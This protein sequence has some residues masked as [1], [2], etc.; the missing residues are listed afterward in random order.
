MSSVT[1]SVL[2]AW[3]SLTSTAYR[4]P[5]PSTLEETKQHKIGSDIVELD[6]TASSNVTSSMLSPHMSRIAHGEHANNILAIARADHLSQSHSDPQGLRVNNSLTESVVSPLEFSQPPTNGGQFDSISTITEG[7]ISISQVSR[8]HSFAQRLHGSDS[9]APAGG[10]VAVALKHGIAA[11][12]DNFTNAKGKVS[13]RHVSQHRSLAGSGHVMQARGGAEKESSQ[14]PRDRSPGR[15]E[16]VSENSG[17]VETPSSQVSRSLRSLG[18]EE[19]R[20]ILLAVSKISICLLV[21]GYLSLTIWLSTNPQGSIY[22]VAR[23]CEGWKKNEREPMRN[24]K[25][26]AR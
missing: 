13:L 1:L 20:D 11:H 26:V 17:N 3:I 10:Q 16:H 6:P 12:N 7:E 8:H 2:A 25:F 14:L 9:L 4:V 22:A 18:R 23:M 15:G 19:V 24:D 21:L 5:T